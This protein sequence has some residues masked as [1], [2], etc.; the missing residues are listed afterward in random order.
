MCSPMD[1]TKYRPSNNME[2][3]HGLDGN[4]M[5]WEDVTLDGLTYLKIS[6]A[7]PIAASNFDAQFPPQRKAPEL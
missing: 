6:Q 5:V 1:R 2:M 4:V 7:V 3:Y